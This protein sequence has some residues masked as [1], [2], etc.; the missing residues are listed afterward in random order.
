MQ[1]VMV[2]AVVALSFLGSLQD[3][4][5]A[6]RASDARTRD[7]YVSVVDNNGKPVTGLTAADFRVRE[8]NVVREVLS[9]AA[10]TEPLTISLLIDDSEAASDAIQYMRDALTAFIERL[11]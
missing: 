10:A 2:A 5:G 3:P 8:D 9:A 6:K 1:H 7:I 4:A 11:D